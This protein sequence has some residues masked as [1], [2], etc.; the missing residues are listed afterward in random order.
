DGPLRVEARAERLP[1]VARS[2][3]ALAGTDRRVRIARRPLRRG[4]DVERAPGR[5]RPAAWTAL[6]GRAARH[7]GCAVVLG[8]AAPAARARDLRDTGGHDETHTRT[9]G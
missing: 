6:A 2:R 8:P 3:P 4:A 9:G 1:V 7:R 5:L